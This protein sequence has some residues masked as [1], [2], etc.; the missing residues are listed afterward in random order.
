MP[1]LLDAQLR[2]GERLAF[3]RRTQS[4]PVPGG[5]PDLVVE[6]HLSKHAAQIVDVH[7]G[8]KA[9]AAACALRAFPCVPSLLV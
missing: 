3:A 8:S 1:L 6:S 9:L 2:S 5:A 7:F 4:L